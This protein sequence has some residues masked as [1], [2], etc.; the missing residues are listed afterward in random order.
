[1]GERGHYIFSTDQKRAP[2]SG[3]LLDMATR[4]PP[5]VMLSCVFRDG[6]DRA[7]LWDNSTECRAKY[8]QGAQL[9]AS[10]RR[11][12]TLSRLQRRWNTVERNDQFVP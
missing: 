5:R 8:P 2:R 6:P 1:M 10:N 7:L 12:R 4:V 3:S 9:V 11:G